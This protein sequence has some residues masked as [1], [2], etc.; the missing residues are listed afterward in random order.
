MPREPA[1]VVAQRIELGRL[2]AE[3]RRGRGVSQ[4]ELAATIFYHRSSITKI[5]NGQQPAPRR[6]WAKADQVLGADGA[7]VKGFDKLA[8][9]KELATAAL[10]SCSPAVAAGTGDPVAG[11]TGSAEWLRPRVGDA[12]L[13]R[14][15]SDART[16]SQV[17]QRYGGAHVLWMVE[18]YLQ[19]EVEPMLTTLPD[20][21]A[22][23][24][25]AAVLHRK[26]G[27]ASFDSADHS[28]AKQHFR[29]AQQMAN[30]AGDRGIEG[31]VLVSAAH[32]AIT[33]A[34][35]AAA[36]ALI[37]HAQHVTGS[38]G[39][40]GL[41]AKIEIMRARAHARMA[42]QAACRSAI[43]RAE[44]LF[45]RQQEANQWISV[46]SEAYLAGQIAHCHQDLGGTHQ[47]VRYA[48]A[49]RD[50]YPST[51]VRRSVMTTCQLAISYVALREVEHAAA[52]GTQALQLAGGLRSSRALTW[53][54]RLEG[55][56][57][58]HRQLPAAAG[59]LDAA[60]A[61]IHDGRG[62][63]ADAASKILAR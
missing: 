8:A 25:V 43:A 38:T 10:P 15:R 48:T 37:E 59:Y 63:S 23:L 17:D 56:L 53:I 11:T 20:D 12:D 18:A 22:I 21:S 36:L 61:V 54:H 31:H 19:R 62:L 3:A 42:D 44:K 14:I 1:H 26:A 52:L 2:L 41:Q 16:F 39:S 7:L 60:D 13:E 58:P 51:Q 30:R 45:D 29:A 33:C 28:R 34:E 24:S 9:A 55:A 4:R 49:A 35:P 46:V 47:A 32:Y 5:E 27:L 57:L 50:R 6:F 40:S